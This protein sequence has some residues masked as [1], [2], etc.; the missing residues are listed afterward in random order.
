M[1]VSG[2]QTQQRG[3]AIIFVLLIMLVAMMITTTLTTVVISNL[4]TATAYNE[5]ATAYYAMESGVERGLYYLQYARDSRTIGAGSSV[6]EIATFAGSVSGGATYTLAPSFV[7][8]A[9]INLATGD[10][11]QWDLYQ[12]DYATGYRLKPMTNLSLAEITWSESASCTSLTS[13]VEVS[14]SVWTEFEWQDITDP[15]TLVTHYTVTCPGPGTGNP[16]CDGYSLGFDD[17]HL[18]KIRVKALNCPI[19]D[20]RVTPIDSLGAQIATTNT[21]QLSGTGE[22]GNSA[23]TGSVLVPWNAALSKYFDY[24]LFSEDAISK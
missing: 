21:I 5:N 20:I 9:V 12:E 19:E 22:Y 3:S 7:D 6:D 1:S 14:F 17:T 10:T 2:Q 16:E 24:V 4:R 13:Q 8:D 18:Y 11:A 15:S 23:R